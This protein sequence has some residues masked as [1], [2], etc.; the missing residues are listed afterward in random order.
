MGTARLLGPLSRRSFL[1][2]AALSAGWATLSH[3]RLP[4]ALAAQPVD[5]ELQVLTPDRA[6]VLTAIVERMV[7]TDGDEMPGVRDTNAIV[8]IDRALRQIDP[9]VRAQLG[10]LLAGFQWGPPVF[11]LKLTT[12]TGMTPAQRDDYLRSWATS[13]YALRRLAFRA[14]KNLAMLGYYSQDATWK[15]IHYDGPWAPREARAVP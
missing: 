5:G 6:E 10:W 2:Y 7:F 14:L 13:R 12:F 9:S 11:Q 8:T 3:L 4:A 15:G 1:R